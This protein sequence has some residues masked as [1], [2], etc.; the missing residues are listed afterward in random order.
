MKNQE[1]QLNQLL[2]PLCALIRLS[3]DSY[4]RYL[5][6]KSYQHAKQI[7]EANK[8]IETLLTANPSLI[9][10]ELRD[11]IVILLNHYQDWFNQF[12]EHESKIK[13]AP[14]DVFVFYPGKEHLPYPRQSEQKIF[15][16]TENL[17][18]AVAGA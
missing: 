18:Q 3:G 9:P 17:K 7:W 2:I 1:D 13:P 10:E 4:T 5:S 16:F 12:M 6:H 8:M 15:Q 11:D 14:N